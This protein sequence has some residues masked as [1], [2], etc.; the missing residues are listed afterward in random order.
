MR[1]T[2]ILFAT[3]ILLCAVF[4]SAL[5]GQA[6]S[7]AKP[8]LIF[9]RNNSNS[10]GATPVVQGDTMGTIWFKGLTASNKTVNSARIRSFITGP[11]SVGNI[12]SNLVFSTGS[13]TLQDRVVITSTGLLGVGTMNPQYNA[14]IV[15]NTHTTGDFYGRIHTDNNPG[16]QAPNTYT[17]E[18]Y[19]ESK[20]STEL[21][22][23]DLNAAGRGGLLTIAPHN[24]A[25][26]QTDHQLYFN[27]DGIFS[28]R[29]VANA[30]SWAG[31]WQ[32]LLTSQD[33]NGTTNRLSKF[34]GP[35]SLGDSQLFDNGTNIGVGTT[36]PSAFLDVNGTFRAAGNAAL[37]ANLNVAGASTLTGA[38]NAGANLNV[39]GA[40][41][42]TGVVNAATNL[43]VAGTSTLTGAVNAGNN[44]NVAGAS[45]LG[46]SVSAGSTLAVT[47][48]AFFQSNATVQG[49]TSANGGLTVQNGA[50]INGNTNLNG[51]KVAIGTTVGANTPGTHALYVNGSI[52]ATEVKVAL[53]GNWPDY[54][55][56]SDYQLPNLT[57]TA[58]YIAANKH[59]PGIPS[60]AEV[61]ENGGIELGEMNRLLLQKIEELTLLMID[62]QKQIDALKT[63]KK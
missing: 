13:P 25:A 43:N 42:L 55:F 8:E 61:Q 63:G 2:F 21:G 38:V 30:A 37:A 14:H 46:G 6:T 60:V 34:T 16:N 62:Q 29:G 1:K 19:F 50:N 24:N 17:T 57:E 44:L 59:L 5:I 4:Q 39:A 28:R 33:I 54:V 23:P 27:T 36:T 35:S 52:V 53:Q 10:G 47:G 58:A 41:T 18:A 40:S 56:E 11:V 26:G 45:F 7:G 51:G 9:Y 49:A 15:G 12:P 31:P 48:T 32:K 3:T 22:A 20:S